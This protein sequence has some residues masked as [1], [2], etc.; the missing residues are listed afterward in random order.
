[1]HQYDIVILL[2]HEA[3]NSAEFSEKQMRALL[4]H[5]LVHAEVAKNDDGEVKTDE[6]GRTCYRIRKHDIEEFTEIVHRH[7]LWKSDLARF[8]QVAMEQKKAPLLR[9]AK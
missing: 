3:W 2:N 1:M 4:D 8:A 5:E 6:Q 7:G 9:M